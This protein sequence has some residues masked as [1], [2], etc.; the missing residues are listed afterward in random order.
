MPLPSQG[1]QNWAAPLNDYI[2]NTVGAEADSAH[3]LIVTHESSVDPHG[4]RAF[5]SGLVTSITSNYGIPNGVAQLGG[6]GR[7]KSTQSPPGGG[8]TNFYDVILDFGAVGNGTHD[9][10]AAMNAALAAAAGA[11]GGEVWVPSGVFA[12]GASLVIGA[13]TWLH[14]S[15]GAKIVRIANPTPPSTMLANYT[16]ST[17]PALGNIHVS[18][19]QWDALNSSIVQACNVFSFFNAGF[20]LV[21]QTKINGPENSSGILLAGVTALNVDSVQFS[22]VA[23]TH[24]RGFNASTACIRIEPSNS[25]VVAGLLPGAYSGLGCSLVSVTRCIQVAATTTDGSGPFTKY[26]YLLATYVTGVTHSNIV[27][28]FNYGNGFALNSLN[29]SSWS[30]VTVVGNQFTNSGTS[31]NITGITNLQA[32]S[33]SPGT[34]AIISGWTA[35][36]LQNGWG[37]INGEMQPSYRV[38]P[39]GDTEIAGVMSGGSANSN[40]II[41]TLPAGFYNTS[42]GCRIPLTQTGSQTLGFGGGTVSWPYMEIDTSGNLRIRNLIS[43]PGQVSFAGTVYITIPNG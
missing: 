7:L 34:G 32:T 35:L 29:P 4:D 11:G 21:E 26:N 19:G 10:A 2:V 12:V 28:A 27:A 18:G 37:P 9:D 24:S 22:G 39:S 13:N 38:T 14:L 6:D 43:S 1:D 40:T 17:L 20:C 42:T 41:A 16:T 31:I 33:N 5:A 23:P 36:S 15:P 3:S 25:S 8:V 30:T